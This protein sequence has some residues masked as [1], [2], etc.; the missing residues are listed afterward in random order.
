[1]ETE[2]YPIAPNERRVAGIQLV[3]AALLGAGGLMAWLRL[4]ALE[5]IPEDLGLFAALF[6]PTLWRG[7]VLFAVSYVLLA[8][9][10]GYA[11]GT[12][13]AVGWLA[14]GRSPAGRRMTWLVFLPVVLAA[15]FAAGALVVA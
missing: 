5:P 2:R 3:I 12:V 9:A 13:G 15:V 11:L 14:L 10:L 8:A 4:D 6:H 1:M 7:L